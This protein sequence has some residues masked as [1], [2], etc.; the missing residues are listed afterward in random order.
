MASQYITHG[1]FGDIHFFTIMIMIFFLHV[2]THVGQ[3]IL[4]RSIT[5]GVITSIVFVLPY[6]IILL[7]SLFKHQI[8]N[9]N[10][11]YTSMPFT[12]W[13]FLFYFLLIGLEKS[14]IK[15]SVLMETVVSMSQMA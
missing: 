15:F 13:F 12:F 5:P 11:I 9:W 4:L 6:S 1:P 7:H 3:S 10:T 8:I 2:F 14:N